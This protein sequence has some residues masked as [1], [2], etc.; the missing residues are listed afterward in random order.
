M[1]VHNTTPSASLVVCNHCKSPS[2]PTDTQT[3]GYD[4]KADNF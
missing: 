3:T 4:S 2:H 1:E